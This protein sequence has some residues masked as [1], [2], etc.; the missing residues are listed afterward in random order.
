[1]TALLIIGTASSDT[2]HL[3]D[4]GTHHAPG[5]A[6][7]YTALAAHSA[8]AEVTLLAPK[9]DPLSAPFDSVAARMRWI[10]PQC[11]PDALPKLEIAHHGG[12]KATLMGAAW[13]AEATL[14]PEAIPADL[15][16][17]DFVHIAALS[18]AARQRAFFDAC[19]QRGARR[20]SVGT[21]ARIATNETEAVRALIAEADAFFMNDNEA[22]ILFGDPARARTRADGLL[23]VTRGALGAWAIQGAHTLTITAPPA[24]DLD[25]TGAGD[26][27]CGVTL[28]L[29]AQ[30]ADVLEACTAGCA[31]ASR[32]IEHPGPGYFW[33]RAQ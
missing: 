25:P 3:A 13:G 1:M 16:G 8:N 18:S 14:T 26:T 21:Y 4:G 5:G 31:A 2:L 27:F 32:M 23:C 24:I 10:G 6:G 15:S 22:G 11:A 12:G 30:G 17:F 19:R 9:P 28:A 33:Q 29:L 20:I 7:L